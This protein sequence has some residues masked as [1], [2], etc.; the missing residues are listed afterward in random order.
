MTS[1]RDALKDWLHALWSTA[2]NSTRGPL[3]PDCKESHR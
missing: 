1:V 3:C 2:T